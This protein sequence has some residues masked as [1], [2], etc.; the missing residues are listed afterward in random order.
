MFGKL[1]CRLNLRHDWHVEST[2]D[3][4]R[5]KQCRRC[6]KYDDRGGGGSVATGA[7]MGM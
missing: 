3:G 2:D 7:P 5:F 6:G 4:E 1:L